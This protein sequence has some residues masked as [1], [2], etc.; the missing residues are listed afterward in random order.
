MSEPT[1]RIARVSPRALSA[2]SGLLRA[3]DAV[4]VSDPHGKRV[5]AVV[6]RV[7]GDSITVSMPSGELTYSISRDE[8]LC[9][10]CG[11]PADGEV[12]LYFGRVLGICE[13]CRA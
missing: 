7:E 13:S 12:Q 4:C 11:R 6:T 1:M 5:R 9:R 8:V 2:S 10:H 3:G